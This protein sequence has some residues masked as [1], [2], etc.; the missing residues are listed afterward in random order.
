M[1]VAGTR[2]TAV[3]QS[4]EMLTDP[5]RLKELA[6]RTGKDGAF[7]A[8]YEVYGVDRTNM[9]ARLMV[10]APLESAAIWS[11]PD[12]EQVQAQATADAPSSPAGAVLRDGAKPEARSQSEYSSANSGRLTK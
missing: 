5:Q 8:L 11:E 2:D 7:E 9:E 4:A 12:W 1:I 10:A 6:D 3:M